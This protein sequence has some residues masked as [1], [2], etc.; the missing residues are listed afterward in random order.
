MNGLARLPRLPR[1]ARP[2]AFALAA[3]LASTASAGS[4][5]IRPPNATAPSKPAAPRW[6]DAA[7]KHGGSGIRLRYE[8]PAALQAGVP[9][10]LQLQ[11]SGIGAA[12]ARV[13]LR[14]PQG[15]SL[16]DT[17]G[18]AVGS[19]ALPAGR[20]TTL[21]LRLTPALDGLQTLDV[22][23]SQAQ[24]LSAQSVP[25]KVGSGKPDL[26]TM[27]KPQ[28]MPDGEKVISLPAQTR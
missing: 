5:G 6:T 3:A 15:A 24:R 28:T 7:A 20:T 17:S 18:N 14:A 11:F 10:E 25:L 23:T 12:D 13:E 1:L 27:G 22:F 9:A 16:T 19:V 2:L 8:V 21:R 26:K 4:D